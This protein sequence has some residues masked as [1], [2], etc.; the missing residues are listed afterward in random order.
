MIEL[1]PITLDAQRLRKAGASDHEILSEVRRRG[2]GKAQSVVIMRQLGLSLIEAKTF[3][4]ESPI[5]A[6]AWARDENIL[7][8]PD[9][10]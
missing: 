3:V 7:G 1:L 9:K 4:H 8:E 6:D 10:G 2:Y 5:W